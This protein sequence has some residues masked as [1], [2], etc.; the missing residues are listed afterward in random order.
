MFCRFGLRE[1]QDGEWEADP[2]G[3]PAQVAAGDAAAHE[4][5]CGFELLRCSFFGCGAE[6]R[7][8]GVDAHDAAEALRHA[9]G[10]R[11][12]RLAGEKALAAERAS[13]AARIAALEAA[14]SA[15]LEAAR[16]G[17]RRIAAL[18][19]AEAQSGAR[20][21]ALEARGARLD[22]SAMA[23]TGV[24]MFRDFVCGGDR[25]R[26]RESRSGNRTMCVRASTLARARKH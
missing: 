12:A 11:E 15:A 18:E 10:E 20:I 21:A 3:C 2:Q 6:M 14:R 23:E 19:A 1:T 24:G 9:R 4:A 13:G 17:A 26:E 7:R 25:K 16:R 22:S 5:A 8:S